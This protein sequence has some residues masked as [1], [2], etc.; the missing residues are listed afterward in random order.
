ME[1]HHQL[2]SALQLKPLVD[3][4]K[5]DIFSTG[6]KGATLW[7]VCVWFPIIKKIALFNHP[8]TWEFKQCRQNFREIFAW[9][10]DPVFTP[11]ANRFS[12]SRL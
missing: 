7:P 12:H 11:Q 6:Q 8:S 3:V 10:L 5:T 1:M 4:N 9:A 2:I